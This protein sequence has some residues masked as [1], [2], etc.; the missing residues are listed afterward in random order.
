MNPYDFV[1]YPSERE[2]ERTTPTDH[3]TFAGRSG[4]LDCELE[5]L[6]P[7]LVM[8]SEQRAESDRNHPGVFMQTTDGTY[9][10]PG[11]SLKGLV[12]SV[13][14]VLLPSCVATHGG[15]TKHLVPRHLEACRRRDR[16]CPACRVFG[17][18]GRGRNA[19]V[20]RGHVNIGQAEL[21]GAPRVVRDLK[22]VPLSSPRPQHVAFYGTE[23]NPA[24]RKFYFHHHEISRPSTPN[25]RERGRYVEPLAG[26]TEAGEPGATFAFTVSFE[27][28]RE[29]ELQGLVAALVLHDGE[30]QA[31]H[32]L[33]YGKPA[34]L[35][36]VEVRIRRVRMEATPTERYRVFTPP[37]TSYAS[38]SS[39][40]REWVAAARNAFFAA[41]SPS[42]QRMIDILRY[43]PDPEVRYVYP[44]REWFNENPR[45]PISETP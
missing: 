16:L 31:R 2:V 21:Q 35:G 1:P 25:E 27:N 44:S 45:A 10:I 37:A 26:R 15:K 38:D 36:S 32:K 7:L 33:G 43:P 17:A 6:S 23:R 42:V 30:T 19:W 12:R 4:R 18:M 3:D 9:I 40:L 28:L 24:G 39:D 11:T 34:G 41:P 22:L 20:H 8:S 29:R 13:F 14:E 5:A